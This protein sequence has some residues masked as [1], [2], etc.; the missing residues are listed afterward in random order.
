M[1]LPIPADG[2]AGPAGGPAPLDGCRILVVDPHPLGRS[3]AAEAL[4]AGGAEPLTAA[5]LG[6]IPRLLLGRPCRAVL[7]DPRAGGD[8]ADGIVAILHAVP[9]LEGLPVVLA[10]GA[11]PGSEIAGAAA[12]LPR[13]CP[14][15]R[16]IDTLAGAIAGRTGNR[17]AAAP[18][19]DPRLDLRILLA[20]DHPVNRRVAAAMLERL[21][22]RVVAVEDG[23]AAVDAVQA[24]G[25]DGVLM[26]CQMPGMDGF[27]AS[28][29]I[30]AAEGIGRRIPIIALT[31]NAGP[32]DRLRC[33]ASGMDDH[34]AKPV[35]QLDLARVLGAIAGRMPGR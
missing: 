7:A 8:R 17:P 12:W 16:L 3:I 6:E 20:E 15:G 19:A 31:A 22:C 11:A 35:R 4:A 5:D 1:R 25:F 28:Q 26:D 13:P 18:S 2:A 32:E 21:G 34:L 9:G 29:A 30:R 14:A 23:R 27:A 33:L 24:G 10:G